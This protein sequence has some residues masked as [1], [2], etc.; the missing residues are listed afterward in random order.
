MDHRT[1]R[2]DVDG[3]RAVSIILVLL[4]HTGE[5][6]TGGFVGVDVFFVISGFLITSLIKR[7]ID[8]GRFSLRRF[9]IRRVRRILPASIGCVLGT[10]ALSGIVMLPTDFEETAKSAIASVT[11]VAN[12]Y[13]WRDGGYFA[14][15]SDQEPFLHFWSLAVEEQFYLCYPP[16]LFLAA[17]LRRVSLFQC[18]LCLGVL[19][20]L[21][22]VWGVANKPVASFY[23]LPTRA[24]ELAVGGLLA[25]A[26][27]REFPRIGR[28]LSGV[29]GLLMILLAGAS[30]GSRS[31]SWD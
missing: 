5:V 8:E 24:W 1:Y 21:L 22:S 20:F 12:V 3:L 9:W 14:G 17:K 19:S 23:L 18:L 27:K 29:A 30:L 15:P 26:P 11:A 7:E 6:L 10:L 4:F 28:E 13:F 16:F 31:C 2:P 25:F